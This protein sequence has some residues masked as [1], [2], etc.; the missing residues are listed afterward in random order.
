[1]VYPSSGESDPWSNTLSLSFNSRILEALL[2]IAW[3]LINGYLTTLVTVL[4]TPFHSS[5][6]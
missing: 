3:L 1:M 5:T 2:L 6:I 4:F